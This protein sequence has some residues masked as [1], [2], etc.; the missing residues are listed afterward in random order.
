MFIYIT[1]NSLCIL[2][3]TPDLSLPAISP[4]VTVSLF[5]KSV[6]LFLSCEQVLIIF[7]KI[8][9]ISDDIIRYW[10]FSAL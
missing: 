8:P 7:F 2:A 5:S 6:S 9:H 10:S 3:Q 1:C 4:L